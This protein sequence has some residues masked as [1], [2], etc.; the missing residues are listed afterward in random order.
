MPGAVDAHVHVHIPYVRPDGSTPYSRDDFG[1]ASHAAAVGGTTT[2][3]AAQLRESMSRLEE[4]LTKDLPTLSNAVVTQIAI[5]T[6]SDWLIRC[7]L[8]LR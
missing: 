6:V 2:L 4:S 1:S 3:P 7:P 5:G 8:E